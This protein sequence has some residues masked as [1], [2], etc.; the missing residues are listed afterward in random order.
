MGALRAPGR[1]VRFLIT[2][3]LAL[4]KAYMITDEAEIMI[5][6]KESNF[7]QAYSR[8]KMWDITKK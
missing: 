6:R 7:G 1:P 8:G 4:N 5:C 2:R 3:D